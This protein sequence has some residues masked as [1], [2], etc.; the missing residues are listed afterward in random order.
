[1]NSLLLN[2]IHY[3]ISIFQLEPQSMYKRELILTKF[4]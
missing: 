1:M 3:S 2:A 4:F